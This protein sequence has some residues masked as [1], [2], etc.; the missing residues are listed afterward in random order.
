MCRMPHVD[1]AC[2]IRAWML[3]ALQWPVELPLLHET[4]WPPTVSSRLGFCHHKRLSF[5]EQASTHGS[6]SRNPPAPAPL[7]APPHPRFES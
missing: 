2:Q 1:C 6:L 7:P 5:R 4:R 3:L